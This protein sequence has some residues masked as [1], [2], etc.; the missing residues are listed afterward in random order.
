MPFLL[1]RRPTT[2]RRAR[3]FTL[4]EL[5]IV[6]AI[7]GILAAIALPAYNDYVDRSRRTDAKTSILNIAQQFERC[8][9]RESSYT[10]AS[11]PAAGTVG[12]GEG[13]YS[14]A[15]TTPSSSTYAI[16]ATPAGAQTRDS[17]KCSSFSYDQTGARTAAGS[18]GNACWD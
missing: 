13:F 11:C 18:I 5:M 14:L 1:M 6:V 8:Y 16:V 2:N 17:S 15:I 10:G 12:S 9:T 7:I 4:I 3:G